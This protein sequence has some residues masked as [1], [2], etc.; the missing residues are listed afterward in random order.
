M[1]VDPRTLALNI[2]L[3]IGALLALGVIALVVLAI[4]TAANCGVWQARRR[5]AEAE[6]HRR[7][8]RPDGQPYPPASRGMCDRCARACETVY[9]EASGERLCPTCYDRAHG[10]TSPP[11]E[12]PAT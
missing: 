12:P 1:A 2:Y 8:F 9:H 4:W 5:R 11:G 7:R 10:L 3:L 6:Q